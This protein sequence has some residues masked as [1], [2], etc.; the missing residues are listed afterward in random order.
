MKTGTVT[1][2][3]MEYD[4]LREIK[5][6]VEEK[7]RCVT[8][9]KLYNG[10]DEYIQQ[11]TIYLGEESLKPL[12]DELTTELHELRGKKIYYPAIFHSVCGALP[13]RKAWLALRRKYLK[14]LKEYIYV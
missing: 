3:I 12:I 13:S 9:Y 2:S 4:E 5:K 6:A 14:T 11:N 8:Y 1:I 10:V 7:T